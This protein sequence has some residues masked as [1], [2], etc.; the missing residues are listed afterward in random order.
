MVQLVCAWFVGYFYL[1]ESLG[2][3][4][5]DQYNLVTKDEFDVELEETQDKQFETQNLDEDENDE[6]DP[7]PLARESQSPKLVPIV[8]E[9]N[10]VSSSSFVGKIITKFQSAVDFARQYKLCIWTICSYCVISF[11][12]I[13]NDEV[14][15]VW[16]VAPTASGGLDFSIQN[17]GYTWIFSGLFLITFQ[18]FAYTL[19]AAKFGAKWALRS[20]AILGVVAFVIMPTAAVFADSSKP[21]MWISL[22]FGWAL[23][24][25][26]GTMCFTSVNVLIN[27]SVP[28]HNTG[29]A[30]GLAFALSAP[31][32]AIGPAVGGSLMAWSLSNGLSFPFNYYFT[33]LV[34]SVA[35][36]LV[37]ASTA[38]YPKSFGAPV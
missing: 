5:S 20:G 2:T 34:L 21:L 12:Y 37:F 30:N 36:L 35:S 23:R 25:G 10:S 11:V 18:L 17:I 19:I 6:E 13:T 29:T 4:S 31:I 3:Q 32:K 22:L 15:P 1:T 8:P 7:E 33:Y 14:F 9:S 16:A 28:A 26:S 38:M 27:E 24:I